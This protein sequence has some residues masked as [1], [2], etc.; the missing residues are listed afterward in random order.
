MMDYKLKR[1]ESCSNLHEI[2]FTGAFE[3]ANKD[4]K[5]KI[6]KNKMAN[7]IWNKK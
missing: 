4:S 2:S 5:V 6:S 7:L 3:D 1:F